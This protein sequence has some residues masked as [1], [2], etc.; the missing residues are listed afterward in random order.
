MVNLWLPA[1]LFITPTDGFSSPPFG[2]GNP[3]ILTDKGQLV[4]NGPNIN[5]TNFRTAT[6]RGKPV[7]TYWNGIISYRPEHWSWVRQRHVSRFVVQ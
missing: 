5:A 2:Y 3:T 6:Y 4:W 1:Y 7:L